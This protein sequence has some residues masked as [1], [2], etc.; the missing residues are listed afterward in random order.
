[1]YTVGS[2]HFHDHDKVKVTAG[3]L[4]VVVFSNKS[5]LIQ[6]KQTPFSFHELFIFTLKVIN[7]C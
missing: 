6:L 2:K 3:N 4:P 1:M 7:I 5:N